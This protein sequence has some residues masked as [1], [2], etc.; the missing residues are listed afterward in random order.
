MYL[1]PETGIGAGNSFVFHRETNHRLQADLNQVIAPKQ[2]LLG[3][4]AVN[5]GTVARQIHEEESV[6]TSNNRKMLA[7]DGGILIGEHK[8][9]TISGTPDT[10]LDSLG[11]ELPTAV[12]AFFDYQ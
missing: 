3:A 7:A 11:G 4:N 1:E 6:A 8:I 12:G 10:E 9:A 2:R 5:R